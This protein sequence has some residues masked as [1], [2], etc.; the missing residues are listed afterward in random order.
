[1]SRNKAY[2]FV[3]DFL[4]WIE[5]DEDDDDGMPY[6][7]VKSCAD[8][9]D[10]LAADWADRA[11]KV[12]AWIDQLPP[13]AP[14][15]D[16]TKRERILEEALRRIMDEAP[17]SEPEEEDYDDT[18]SAYNNGNDVAWW[19]AK[20]IAAVALR[21]AGIEA[22]EP[23][24]DPPDDNIEVCACGFSA[25]QCAHKQEVGGCRQED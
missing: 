3:R 7:A 6:V 25:D 9:V 1:M 15:A 4:A 17:K 18:E 21:K 13:A 22:A 24:D 12:C 2:E 11:R 19:E 20:S 14:A 16:V 10:L 8:V 5:A 23:S